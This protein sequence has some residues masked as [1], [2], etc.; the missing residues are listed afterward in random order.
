MTTQSEFIASLRADV[1]STTETTVRSWYNAT[2]GNLGGGDWDWCSAFV[3][4]RVARSDVLAARTASVPELKAWAQR[5]GIWHAGSAGLQAGD[6]I[7]FDFNS[8]G[9]PDHTGFVIAINGTTLTTVE[10][11]TGQD[12]PYVRMKTRYASQI[13]GYIHPNFAATSAA[14]AQPAQTNQPTQK[15]EEDMR[16]VRSDPAQGGDG[17]ISIVYTD[18]HVKPLSS[19]I[20][21]NGL[22]KMGIPVTQLPAAEYADTLAWIQR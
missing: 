4:W 11:N 14:P 15:G 5:N 3:S 9:T 19:M 21:F 16:L 12:D 1:G 20:A 2:V 8:N 17:S 18:G 10:G 7:T 6:V 22:V 13:H